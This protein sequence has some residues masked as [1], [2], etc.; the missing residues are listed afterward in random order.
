MREGRSTVYDLRSSA[1]T[2]NDLAQAVRALGAE[3][4]TE[5]S[6]TFDVVVEGPARD[7]QPIVRDE[8]YRITCEALRN[9]FNHARAKQIETEITY[10]E[11]LFRVRV[12]DDGEG[13]P[14]TILEEGRPGH[15]GL[16]GIRE[17]AKQIG[18]TLEI[19]SQA[20][21]GTEIELS[22]DG[23]VAYSAS[24]SRPRFHLFRQKQDDL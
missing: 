22:V 9:A 8:I 19:W 2:T 21:A 4:A 11:R 24:M 7:L 12:R 1:S 20:G 3:L 16:A 17:R 13:I 5:D 6:A 15:Y 23:A 10:G 14:T 18:G